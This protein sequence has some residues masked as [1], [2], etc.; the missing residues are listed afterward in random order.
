MAEISASATKPLDDGWYSLKENY[1]GVETFG[2][3]RFDVM[4]DGNGFRV[5][6]SNHSEYEVLFLGDSFMHGVGVRYEETIPGIFENITSIPALNGGVASYS[7]LAYMFQYKKALYGRLLKPE[8][9][10]IIGID[11]SDIQDEAAIWKAGTEHPIK[12]K[13]DKTGQEYSQQQVLDDD[14]SNA[15]KQFKITVAK[16]LPLTYRTYA[17]FRQLLI[18]KSL[19]TENPKSNSLTYNVPSSIVG[20]ARSSPSWVDWEY[21]NSKSLDA[22]LPLGVEGGLSQIEK[23]VSEIAKL[24]KKNGG[25]IVLF[26]YPWPAQIFHISDEK[27]AFNGW[28]SG[29]CRRIEC[30]DYIPVYESVT[31]VALSDPTWYRKFYIL[32]DVHFNALGNRFIAQE[33]A[34]RFSKDL[35]SIN[36]NQ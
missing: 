22:F 7:P 36:S 11:I 18:D 6:E 2:N 29:L 10:V 1:R 28:V 31:A 20:L 23:S 19:D 21:L 16:K 9:I 13:T 32:G 14:S 12:R 3:I 25:Q 27:F 4:T 8:H 26:T 15:W 30:L 5:G 34:R 17:L 35:Y 33:I 24:A